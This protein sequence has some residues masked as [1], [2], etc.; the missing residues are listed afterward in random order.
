MLTDERKTASS[1]G[2]SP[3]ERLNAL[4]AADMQACDKLILKG[5]GSTV[6]LTLL[7]A[8]TVPSGVANRTSR[9][10]TSRTEVKA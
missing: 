9:S 6:K 7:T 2:I 4:I 10:R 8:S 3:V 5:M 1:A